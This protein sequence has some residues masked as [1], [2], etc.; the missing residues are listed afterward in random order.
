MLSSSV[1]AK[2]KHVPQKQTRV[3]SSPVVMISDST[4]RMYYEKNTSRVVPIASISKLMVAVI[5]LESGLSLDE[6]ITITADDV[7]SSSKLRVGT[8]LTRGEMLNAALMSSD[9]RAAHCLARTITGN[10]KD[11]I[12]LMNHKTTV[13]GMN[14]TSFV[15][16]TGLDKNNK[17]TAADLS[18]LLMYASQNEKITEYST[19]P[20]NLIGKKQFYN[21][22]AY[23]RSGVWDNV[24]VSK[25]G[26]TNAAGKC[27]AVTLSFGE[28]LYDVVIL[29]ARNKKQRLNDLATAKRII[30]AQ[31][32]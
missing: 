24:I 3:F 23:V 26:F 2:H 32:M 11:A 15:E 4:G 20:S 17:S 6:Q 31:I 22:N 29:G 1:A 8:S 27:I 14:A 25:T 7:V 10:M 18:K 28:R 21:T 12:T 16:P 9:N 30:V 5:V 13:L 19:M